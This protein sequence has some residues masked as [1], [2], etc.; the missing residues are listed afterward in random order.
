MTSTETNRPGSLL[1]I[2]EK[3]PTSARE[4]VPESIDG[5]PVEV[6]ESGRGKPASSCDTSTLR[7]WNENDSNLY[8]GY[9]INVDGGASGT[10]TCIVYDGQTAYGLSNYHVLKDSGNDVNDGVGNSIGTV[11]DELHCREDWG[12]YSLD[13]V[14]VAQEVKFSQY[15]GITGSFTKDGV[16]DLVNSNADCSKVGK[17]TCKSTFQA[18]AYDTQYTV[19]GDCN[20]APHQVY[21]EAKDADFD[22]GDSGSLAYHESPDNSSYCWAVSQ[23][24]FYYP[25]R[26]DHD[27]SGVGAWQIT[28]RGYYFSG[29]IR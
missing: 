22:E 18:E 19:E 29:S 5:V 17:R 12:L 14:G 7:G 8:S 1:L 16:A 13:D 4:H 25:Y 20:T 26:F 23:L 28:D 10:N 3:N 9:E 21:Y 15:D 24:A 27:I 11:T 6:R 2:D